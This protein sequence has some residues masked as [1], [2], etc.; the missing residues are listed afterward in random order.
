MKRLLSLALLCL[1]ACESG[2]APSAA[3]RPATTVPSRP[4]AAASPTHE[5]EPAP[6]S[7]I[8]IVTGGAEERSALPLVVAIHGLGDSPRGFVGVFH[9]FGAK[10]RVLLPAG[11]TP[12]GR[13]HS[14][15]PF[16]PGRTEAELAEGIREAAEQV[17][18][19]VTWAARARPTQGKPIITGFSQ[20][21]MV[22]FAVAVLYP[23]LVRAAFPVGGALPRP[24]WPDGAPSRDAP[25]I[26][27]LHGE[28]D[29]VVPFEPTRASVEHLRSL[30]F[31]VKL[32]RFAGVGHSMPP[33]VRTALHDALA[34]ALARP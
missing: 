8:E 22:S 12:Y 9:G 10:A 17:R 18:A 30:G 32:E 26:V 33:P 24:L 20:G 13:G 14:W 29:S 27:A 31:A 11:P 1:A 19:F 2:S 4:A 21:G 5:A 16:R 25:P 6:L 34:E 3:S 7:F 15:F 23:T 28:T